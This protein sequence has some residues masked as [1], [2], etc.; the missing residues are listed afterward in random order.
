MT[1]TI[2]LLLCRVPGT[3]TLTGSSD[4]WSCAHSSFE[5]LLKQN[6]PTNNSQHLHVAPYLLRT[7]SAHKNVSCVRKQYD[8][9]ARTRGLFLEVP[10]IDGP[11]KLLLITSKTELSTVVQIT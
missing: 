9:K 2:I 4:I 11:G 8:S 7:I 10:I 1:I 5:F 3:V 6:R